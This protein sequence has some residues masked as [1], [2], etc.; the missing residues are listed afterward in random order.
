MGKG[1]VQAPATS[2]VV[3]APKSNGGFILSAVQA[4][5]LMP[6]LRISG[7]NE[8]TRSTWSE[9]ISNKPM[10]SGRADSLSTFKTTL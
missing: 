2:F 1:L 5:P 3:T 9:S 4:L 7:L 10:R 8:M 6:Y